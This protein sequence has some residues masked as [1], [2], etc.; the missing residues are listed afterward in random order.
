MTQPWW[1][2]QDTVIPK[3]THPLSSAWDQPDMTKVLIDDKHAVMDQ[4]TFDELL[5]YSTSVPTAVYEGK[6]WKRQSGD[7]WF[8]CWYDYSEIPGSCDIKAR[9]VLLV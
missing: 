6:A 7:T 4:K 9:K 8:L 2:P 3:M 1:A 5:E